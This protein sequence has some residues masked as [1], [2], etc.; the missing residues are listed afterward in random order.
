MDEIIEMTYAEVAGGYRKNKNVLGVVLFGSV[1]RG[2]NDQ[3]SDIDL[4]VILKNRSNISRKSFVKN[5]IKVEILF[6]SFVDVM[7]YLKEE[8]KNLHRNVSQMFA[9]AKILYEDGNII[10]EIIEY[11]RKIIKQRTDYTKVE[12][13]MNKYSI[14]DYYSDLDRSFRYN[15][16]IS[17]E[18]NSSL[19]VKN[20]IELFLKV[21]GGFL[22]QPNEMS[23]YLYGLDSKFGDM[24]NEYFS[25]TKLEERYSYFSEIIA[26]VYKHCNGSL[27]EE[28]SI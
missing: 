12:L 6:D 18:L 3:Y 7:Q 17:F 19:I 10:S 9:H 8:E 25:L 24:L 11:S 15:D 28:W 5:S 26:Y 1:A 14:D 16:V 22:K 2:L 13:I 4:Y 20:I 21:N 23:D 27:P